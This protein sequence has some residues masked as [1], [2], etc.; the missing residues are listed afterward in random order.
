[1]SIYGFKETGVS[2][3][4]IRD[5]IDP[6]EAHESAVALI[7]N[8]CTVVMGI[9]EKIKLIVAT[10]LARGHILLEDT[11]GT[12]KT[13]ALKAF[14]ASTEGF[15]FKRTQC[16]P[17]LLPSDITGLYIFN[18]RTREFEFRPGA[19]FANLA[20]ADEINRATPKTLSALLEAMA[21]GTVSLEGV[22]HS[23]PSPFMVMATQNPIESSG[24]FHIGEAAMDRFMIRV[25]VGYPNEI[26][27]LRMLASQRQT[28]PLETLQTVVSAETLSRI[29]TGLTYPPSAGGLVY[30]DP[31]IEEY[32]VR[33]VR[34][35]RD[36]TKKPKGQRL[37]DRGASPRG[38]IN[39]ARLARAYAFLDGRDY[40]TPRDVKNLA[41]PV[42]AHRIE[43]NQRIT[44]T[45]DI[46]LTST[47]EEESAIAE[48]IKNISIPDIRSETGWKEK[49][50]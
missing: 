37:L 38:S 45:R 14:A 6:A 11:P 33:I 3:T 13:T 21:E 7:E 15:V 16:T 32:I 1:M 19:V 47:E 46:E 42:L 48:L 41:V 12:G 10:F 8:I 9:E 44:K 26:S 24:V 20:L 22:T 49:R 39:L 34:A 17:D 31:I 27:E 5:P 28:H 18:Q 36:E 40:V 23:L 25:S 4:P 2:T 35:T 29:Q 43:T 50:Y 30:L